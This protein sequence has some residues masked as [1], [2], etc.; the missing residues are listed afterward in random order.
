MQERALR[1]VYNDKMSSYAN[2][3]NRGNF[4]SLSASRLRF[5]AIEMYK[6]RRNLAP[7]YLCD[8]FH[9]SVNRYELRDSDRLIQPKFTT[10]KYGYR[11]FSYYGSKLWNNLPSDIKNSESL[12]IFKHRITQWCHSS[13]C[14]NLI[15]E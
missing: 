14:E 11:S 13:E 8:L 9:Q 3:L 10:M 6:C 2:L 5:L 1:F 12:N 7:P 4:L 15:I